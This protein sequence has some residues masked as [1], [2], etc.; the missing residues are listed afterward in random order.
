MSLASEAEERLFNDLFSGY[1]RLIRPV[2][3]NTETLV[4][5]FG[6]TMSQLIDVVRLSAGRLC[7]WGPGVGGLPSRGIFYKIKVSFDKCQIGRPASV[8]RTGHGVCR[9]FLRNIESHFV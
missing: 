3:N 4:V 2:K 8:A 6:L 5:E 7:L 1:N 9:P